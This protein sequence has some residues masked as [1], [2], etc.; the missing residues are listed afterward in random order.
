MSKLQQGI[1]DLASKFPELAKEWHP[2]LN[3]ITPDQVTFA[4]TIKIYW[5]CT[6]CEYGLNGEWITTPS[7]R[8][9]NKLQHLNAAPR[10]RQSTSDSLQHRGRL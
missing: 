10:V 3:T 2:T 8:T 5:Q 6:K 4:S 1:N 7:R 9:A